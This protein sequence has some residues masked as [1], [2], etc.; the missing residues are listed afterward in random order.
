MHKYSINITKDGDCYRNIWYNTIDLINNVQFRFEGK[1]LCK[2]W[3]ATR[4]IKG[5]WSTY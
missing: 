3:G 4:N 2:S 1:F 5:V